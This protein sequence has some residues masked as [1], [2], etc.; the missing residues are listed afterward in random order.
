L[1]LAIGRDPRWVMGQLGHTD[2]RLTLGLYAQIIQR[3]RVDEGLIWSL[4]RF[5]DEA[6]TRARPTSIET[7]FET[8]SSEGVPI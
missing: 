5:P 7:R 1:A 4:M 2:A 3:K 8:T 6:E